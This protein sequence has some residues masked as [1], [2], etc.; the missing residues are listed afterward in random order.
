MGV[1]T[2][3]IDT[4][5]TETVV[6]ETVAAE[7]ANMYD[8]EAGESSSDKAKQGNYISSNI[9]KLIW[10]LHSPTHI[11]PT[12]FVLFNQY[13]HP[14]SRCIPLRHAMRIMEIL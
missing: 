13:L 5:V 4:V 6:T 3:E 2:A 12:K 9:F 14:K 8:D 11:A 1:G 10:M 7:N